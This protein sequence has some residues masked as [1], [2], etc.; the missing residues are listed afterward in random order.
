MQYSVKLAQVAAEH[1][2]RVAYAAPDFDEKRLTSA[3]LNR[4]GIQLLGH[5]SYFDTDRL[6]VL[7][8]A[9][10]ALLNEMTPEERRSAFAVLMSRGIPAVIVAHEEEPFPECL[11]MAEKYG[12]SVFTTDVDTSEFYAQLIGTLR[13]HL[14]PRQTIHGVLVEVHGEGMLITGD[15]GI[16][17]SETALELIKRGHR[18]I[19]DDA[20]EIRRTSRTT[21]EG[22]SPE[23]IQYF[24]ELR[25]I[26]VINVEKVFGIGA[27]RPSCPIDMVVYMELWDEKRQYDR[28]GIETESVSILDVSV[29]KVTIP[30]RPGRNLAVILEIAAMTNRQ[31][32]LGYSAAEELTRRIDANIDAGIEF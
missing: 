17:K 15:S 29:P 25:G 18:L 20:V 14:A 8:K 19:A 5:L 1:S 9:E 4:P 21:L 16:G 23:L 2:L 22:R 10:T 30:V 27:V 24:M 13:R 6:Q 26:G 3:D 31:K 11:E 7:G 28:L 32:M 12:V